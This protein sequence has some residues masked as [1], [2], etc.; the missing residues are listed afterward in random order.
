ME[1]VY[2]KGMASDMKENGRMINIMV[3]GQKYGNKLIYII[4]KIKHSIK[5]NF[6]MEKNMET[7][8]YFFETVVSM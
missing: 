2:T 1:M 5:D 6:C 7:A 8:N 4:Y 3:T